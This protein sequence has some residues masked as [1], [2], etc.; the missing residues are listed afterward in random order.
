[1][2]ASAIGFIGL[3]VMGSAMALNLTRAENDVIVWNRTAK[4]SEAIAAAG[5][6]VARD[7]AGVF[8][9]SDVVFLMLADEEAL[10]AVLER[11][12]PNFAEFVRGHII[13][14]MGTVAPQYSAVLER[15]I[16]HAG[17]QYVEC[18][19]SGSRVPAEE[20]RLVAMLAGSS[21]AVKAI[22]PLLAPMC[23][24][25]VTCGDVPNALLMKFAVNIFLIT[26]VSGLAEAFHFAERHGLNMEQFR[27]VVD[28]GP[29]ASSVSRTK[30]EKMLNEDFSV[31]AAIFDVLK[32]SRLISEQ[33]RTS[34]LAS[35]L[36]DVS[37]ELF[38]ET[39][40]SGYDSFDMAAVLLA[41]RARTARAEP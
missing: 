36:L 15:D 38:G 40:N 19:V 26:T 18:P 27:A 41:L 9:D 21:E 12:T 11:G 39:S 17:G 25:A 35:P 24:E 29:M 1:M 3:G 13:V 2:A 20:G 34:K 4:K 31:Q 23:S 5:A 14:Q 28:A 33:A 32:N 30:V 6:S 22:R 7:K 37:H 10:D 8:A 16:R